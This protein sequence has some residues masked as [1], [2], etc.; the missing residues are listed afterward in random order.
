MELREFVSD[1]LTQI[2]EGISDAIRKHPG[3]GAGAISP[4]VKNGNYVDW[5]QY[6]KNVEFDVAVTTTDK[7]AIE[8]E[9]KIEVLKV[10]KIGGSGSSSSENS[11]ASRIKFSVSMIFPTQIVEDD[12]RGP[13]A[14]LQDCHQSSESDH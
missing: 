5:D 13:Y 9:G 3:M 1:V 4:A 6:I 14:S 2:R 12:N 10:F 7:G 8:G 11:T